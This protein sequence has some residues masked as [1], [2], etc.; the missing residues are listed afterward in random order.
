VED[1][2]IGELR[3]FIEK[4]CL[5]RR[6]GIKLASG[7]TSNVYLDC[8]VALM[9]PVAL[10]LIAGLM[11]EKINELPERPNAIGGAIVGAVPITAAII[12]LNT[13]RHGKP[14]AGFMVRRDV[15]EHGLQKKVRRLHRRRHQRRRGGGPPDR[16]RDASGGS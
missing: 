2:R 11:L 16:L 7:R 13:T 12:Q 9:H 6:E 5:I 14:L 8:R 10:P 15:K 1:G 4:N 3:R